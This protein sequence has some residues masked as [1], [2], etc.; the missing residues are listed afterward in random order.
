VFVFNRICPDSDYELGTNKEWWFSFLVQ[1][2]WLEPEVSLA[3]CK[4]LESLTGKNSI[5]IY[6][7]FLEKMNVT[8]NCNNARGR[9]IKKTNH[10]EILEFLK[11]NEGRTSGGES[12]AWQTC[13]E[14]GYVPRADPKYGLFGNATFTGIGRENCGLYGEET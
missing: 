12:W 10:D 9:S 13:H 2:M 1:N 7:K 14:F 3:Q 6:G 5:E 8:G 4:I 11:S